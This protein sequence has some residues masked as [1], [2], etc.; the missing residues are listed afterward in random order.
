[1][2]LTEVF[3]A[4][5]SCGQTSVSQGRSGLLVSPHPSGQAEDDD[6]AH[7][8]DLKADVRDGSEVGDDEQ[9]DLSLLEPLQIVEEDR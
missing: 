7:S 8:G 2:P 5:E 1:M 9:L 6:V 4:E 3:R